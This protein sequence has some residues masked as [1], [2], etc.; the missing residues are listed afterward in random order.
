MPSCGW[1]RRDLFGQLKV[2]VKCKRFKV[3]LENY[4]SVENVPWE[5]ISLINLN[6]YRILHKLQKLCKIGITY[7]TVRLK[8]DYVCITFDETI[9]REEEYTPI[10]KRIC[11]IDLNPN[12]IAVVVRD[13]EEIIHNDHVK[14]F[15]A[16]K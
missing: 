6:C 3:R 5:Q 1:V 8:K 2:G 10:N 15:L 14:D 16:G 11:A 12:Y 7:F 4:V 9:L 13:K